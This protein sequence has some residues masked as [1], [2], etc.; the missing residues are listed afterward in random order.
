MNRDFEYI[1][2]QKFLNIARQGNLLRE[3]DEMTQ[4][5][6][7]QDK[8]AELQSKVMDADNEGKKITLDNNKQATVVADVQEVDERIISGLQQILNGYLQAINN[9]VTSVDLITVHIGDSS[10]VVT[11]KVTMDDNQPATLNVNSETQ[12][13]QLKYDNFLKLSE[14]NLNM[15]TASF[16]YFNAT[17][18][19]QLQGTV[20]IQ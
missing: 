2:M 10:L 15:M 17:L 7:M 6:V 9:F 19:T 11:V 13:V 4:P 14:K 18:M 16:R 8:G 20:T 12:D 1:N 3:Q 5:N